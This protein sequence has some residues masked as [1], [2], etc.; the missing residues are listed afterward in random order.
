[1][2]RFLTHIL[3]IKNLLGMQRTTPPVP[4]TDPQIR[5]HVSGASLMIIPTFTTGELIAQYTNGGELIEERYDTS[6]S[7]VSINFNS[8]DAG[9][10]VNIINTED[11]DPIDTIIIKNH[12]DSVVVREN[13]DNVKITDGVEVLNIENADN[14]IGVGAEDVPNFGVYYLFAI[15][16]TAA[17]RDSCI[18]VITNNIHSGSACELYIDNT[19]PYAADVITAA[20]AQGWTIYQ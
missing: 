12:A 3:D 4:I 18:D 8:T 1:M 5:I 13:V 16:Q 2:I 19:Q 11:R 6:Y 7:G 15:A 17:Q 20:T 9:W 10:W 14:L